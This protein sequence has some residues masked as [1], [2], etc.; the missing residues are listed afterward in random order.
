MGDRKGDTKD[1]AKNGWGR[2][3]LLVLCLGAACV[4]DHQVRRENTDEQM[5]WLRHST[6]EAEI[7]QRLGEPAR[8]LESGRILIW[9]LENDLQPRKTPSDDWYLGNFSRVGPLSLVVVF[10]GSRCVERASLVRLW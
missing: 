7:V 8:Q 2:S 9:T 3:L 5:P 6:L 1:R 10:D 4:S